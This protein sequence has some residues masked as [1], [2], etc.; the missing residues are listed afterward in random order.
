MKAEADIAGEQ[1]TL[2]V[3]V[4]LPVG[5]DAELVCERLNAK[6]IAAVACG[7]LEELLRAMGPDCGGVVVGE[8]ALT[9]GGTRRLTER[10][11]E[12]PA[13]SSLPVLM[14]AGRGPHETQ[15]MQRLSARRDITALRR[16]VE[17]ATLTGIVREGIQ[18][19]SRQLEVRDLLEQLRRRTVEMEYLAMELISAEE[20]ERSRI[21]LILHDDLQQI[22]AYAKL[23]LSAAAGPKEER[24]EPFHDALQALTRA[25]AV[26]RSLSCELSPP[27][28]HTQGLGAALESL[29][30]STREN[31]GLNVQTA[32]DGSEMDVEEEIR[33]FAYQA[34]SELLFNVAKHAG[35]E[36]VRLELRREG[37]MFHLVVEDRGAGFVPEKLKASRDNGGGS[38][39]FRI[40]QRAGLLGGEFRIESARGRGSRFDLMLP[41][42]SGDQ[43]AT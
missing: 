39:L 11:D 40:E 2:E 13:W 25:I 19:R 28:L 33:T 18:S 3:A 7:D 31:H 4:L 21:A 36:T 35:V 24:P 43:L 1:R 37:D 8:E 26:S 34:A 30:H 42:D 29:A 32:I 10:L 27:H 20:R 5:R 38:G 16:P 9:G 17:A 14:L 41:L 6:G 15:T 23:R 22:L 12:Q